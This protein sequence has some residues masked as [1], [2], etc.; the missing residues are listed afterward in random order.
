MRFSVGEA[1][2]LSP[3]KNDPAFRGANASIIFVHFESN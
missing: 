1:A 3:Q 2:G